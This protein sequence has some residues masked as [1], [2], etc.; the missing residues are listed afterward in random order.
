MKTEKFNIALF[1]DGEQQ[2]FAVEVKMQGNNVSICA[3]IYGKEVH[4]APDEQN[5][6]RPSPACNLDPELLY[7]VGR[8]IR[9][10]RPIVHV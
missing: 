9:R 2:T 5:S 4:F 8:A 3:N 10:Q 7:Q 1:R 6:L